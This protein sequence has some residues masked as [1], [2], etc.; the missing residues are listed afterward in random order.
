M[1]RSHIQLRFSAHEAQA[2]TTGGPTRGH[3]SSM[4]RPSA[5][6]G[7]Q[8]RSQGGQSKERR[9]PSLSGRSTSSSLR[10]CSFSLSF[11]CTPPTEPALAFT[12]TCGRQTD[13]TACPLLHFTYGLQTEES[14]QIYQ[15]R[16]QPRH[17]FHFFYCASGG[18]RQPVT[19]TSATRSF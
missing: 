19:V 12:V 14:C 11:S 4:W 6:A 17:S 9:S 15:R 3:S 7:S 5:E 10:T 2:S 8:R 16:E 18:K 13:S 1:T